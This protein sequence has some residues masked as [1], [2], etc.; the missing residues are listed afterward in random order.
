VQTLDRIAGASVQLAELAPRLNAI[1][2]ELEAAVAQ[3]EDSA[4][5]MT[6][7][8][9]VGRRIAEHTRIVSINAAIEAGRAGG[10]G[11]AF[12]AVVEEIQRLADASAAS[13]RDV[14]SR[15][16]GIASAIGRVS[17]AAV[18]PGS[19]AETARQVRSLTDV[20]LTSVGQFRFD[21]HAHAQRAVAALIPELAAAT[22]D[23]ARTESVLERWLRAHPWFELAYATDSRG[24]QTV[25]NLRSAG[26]AVSRD[27]SAMD[28]DWSKRPWFQNALKEKDSCVSDFYR[29][30]ATGDFCFTV[31]ARWEAAG[32]TAGVVGADVNFSRIVIRMERGAAVG[33]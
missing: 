13:A 21:A 10:A 22:G 2:A 5:Q 27:P 14:E 15:V 19:A 4:A 17:T 26:G 1:V 33:L 8:L 32:K 3:L 31:S 23:R 16:S 25:S 18:G 28:Q 30:A 20:L 7:A 12:T 24:R 11:G 29:S 9:A 6:Q